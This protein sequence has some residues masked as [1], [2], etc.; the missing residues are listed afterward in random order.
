LYISS[1]PTFLDVYCRTVQGLLD[2]FR[3]DLGFTEL[4]FIQIDLCVMCVF[5]HL[6][7]SHLLT[8]LGR[9][10]NCNTLQHTAAYCNTLQH[11]ATHCYTLLHSTPH[12]NILQHNTTHCNTLQHAAARCDTMQ[13]TATHPKPETPTQKPLRTPTHLR[14]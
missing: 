9:L 2:W 12:C 8:L 4:L 1:H 10:Q 5:E 11:T 7:S 6:E 3:V 14:H 13:H